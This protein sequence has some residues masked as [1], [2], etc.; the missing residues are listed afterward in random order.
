M[1]GAFLITITA[2]TSTPLLV[3]LFRVGR[4]CVMTFAGVVIAGGIRSRLSNREKA[5]A[6]M[7]RGVVL[8]ARLLM[9]SYFAITEAR[10]RMNDE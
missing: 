6:I 10:A 8:G 7:N 4:G 1:L 3:S 5:P 2:R 9:A